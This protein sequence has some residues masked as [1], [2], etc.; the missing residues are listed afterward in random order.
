MIGQESLNPIFQ[1]V[2]VEEKRYEVG[3]LDILYI[4]PEAPHQLTNPFNE[5]FGFFCIV[6]AKRDKPRIIKNK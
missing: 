3:F 5:P 2:K 4:K 1:R 6:N